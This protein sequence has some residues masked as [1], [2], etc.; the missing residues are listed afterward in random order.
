[1]AIRIKRG[2]SDG[3][4]SC[5]LI[6]RRGSLAAMTLALGG[7][8]MATAWAGDDARL[9]DFPNHPITIVVPSSAGNVNDAVARL[10]GRELQAAWGQPVVVEN[11]PGAG[12]LTGT[13]YVAGAPKDGHTLLLTFTA[14]VQ[15][16][17]LFR[18]TG[19]DPIKDFA[20]VS[21]VALSAVILAAAPDAEAKTVPD[22]VALVKA[23]P[24]ELAYG[25]Y[26]VGTTGHILGELFK[27]E[28]GLQM[29][30]VAYKGGA[31]LA[32]D[33]AAGHVKYGWIAVGTAIPLIK[34]GKL[35]P[36]AFAGAQRSALMPDVPTMSELGYRGFEPDAWMG[37]LAPAGTPVNR[38][39]A[40]SAQVARIVKMP[41][42][43]K[44]M[45]DMNL[46]PVG[47]TPAQFQSRLEEDLRTWSRAIHEL[48]IT[49]E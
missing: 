13:K 18:S 32:N 46:V 17:S 36:V 44:R 7:L 35:Q 24:G 19:Y 45:H 23:H 29:A 1:M 26:G 14:H 10:I 22:I 16:P 11:R 33:L 34:A 8:S 28:A 20:A 21:E 49:L 6:S 48:G 9:P 42:M 41:E 5:A 37:L 12:T 4:R 2:S 15:N 43:T 39:D 25:S 40:L 27:R 47:S 3:S 31:P 38:I 30:H